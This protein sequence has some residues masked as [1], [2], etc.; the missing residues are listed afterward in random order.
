MG[1][2]VRRYIDFH[3]LLI[4]T[5]SFCSSIPISLFI[6]KTFFVFFK[7][8]LRTSFKCE[9]VIIVNCDFSPST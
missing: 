4:P 3:I 9:H 8:Y 2:V 5:H 6:L 1:V 7:I